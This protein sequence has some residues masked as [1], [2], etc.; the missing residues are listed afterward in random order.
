MHDI[1][2][3]AKIERLNAMKI[4]LKHLLLVLTYFFFFFF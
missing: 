1:S 4:V 3:M 2:W